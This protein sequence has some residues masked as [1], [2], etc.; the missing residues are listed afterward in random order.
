MALKVYDKLKHA[1]RYWLLRRLPVCQEVVKDISRSMEQRLTLRERVVVRV[2][3][4]TCAWC[5][6]Y[7]EHLQMIHYASHA[8]PFDNSDLPGLSVAAR[9]RIRNK[10][11][12]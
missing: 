1:M 9:E 5:Q 12:S 8:T 10:L 2:H 11:M 3:L 7:L 4:W 6:W